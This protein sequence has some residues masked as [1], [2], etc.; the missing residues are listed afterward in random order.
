M[1]AIAETT[2]YSSV[3]ETIVAR[4]TTSPG[5][6]AV[7]RTVDWPDWY[8]LPPETM[9]SK[10][11]YTLRVNGSGTGVSFFPE[12]KLT[13]TDMKIIDAALDGSSQFLY[14]LE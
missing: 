5:L 13:T 3:H 2:G 11:T 10:T 7:V 9:H 1:M 8:L 14:A 12:R 6:A 4:L